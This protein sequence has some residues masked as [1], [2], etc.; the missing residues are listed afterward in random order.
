MYDDVRDRLIYN[1]NS[2][3]ADIE[4]FIGAINYDIIY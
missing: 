2:V 4:C 3:S 1:K